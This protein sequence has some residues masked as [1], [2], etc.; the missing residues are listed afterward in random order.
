MCVQKGSVDSGHTAAPKEQI[1][2]VIILKRLVLVV[3]G[4]RTKGRRSR[5]TDRKHINARRRTPTRQT[6]FF[7]LLSFLLLIL[8]SLSFASLSL[9][10]SPTYLLSLPSLCLTSPRPI[11]VQ[12]SAPQTPTTTNNNYRHSDRQQESIAP[13]NT[14][15]CHP[16]LRFVLFFL[17]RKP[18]PGSTSK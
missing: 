16:N 4:M 6:L 13:C 18:Y 9:S 5:H 12:Q 3:A 1:T 8:L 7:C 17:P 10:H 14:C 11:L 2:T 15:P